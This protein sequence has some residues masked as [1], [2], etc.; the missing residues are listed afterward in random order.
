MVVPY[1]VRHLFLIHANAS[2]A[3]L[4]MKRRGCISLEVEVEVEELEGEALVRKPHYVRLRFYNAIRNSQEI[5]KRLQQ[6]QMAVEWL[7]FRKHRGK[8]AESE[9]RRLTSPKGY[10]SLSS[11]MQVV[12]QSVSASPPC[13]RYGHRDFC[14]PRPILQTQ[15]SWRLS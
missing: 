1:A 12:T 11:H 4:V 7:R 6:R 14:N 15:P 10:Q 2:L 8:H 13:S 5:A 9:S 3:R